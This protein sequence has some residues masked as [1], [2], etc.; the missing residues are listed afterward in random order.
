[1]WPAPS[2]K[3]LKMARGAK[4]FGHPCYGGIPYNFHSRARTTNPPSLS[5]PTKP[6]FFLPRSERRGKRKRN[7]RGSSLW[8]GFFSFFLYAPQEPKKKQTNKKEHEKYTTHAAP[9]KW[10]RTWPVAISNWLNP[11]ED[12]KPKREKETTTKKRQSAEKQTQKRAKKKR[13]KECGWFFNKRL[14]ILFFALSNFLVAFFGF[15]FEGV[16]LGDKSS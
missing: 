6:P 2:S 11:Q 1:M 15:L 12:R 4:K 7:K 16:G 3:F 5:V 10:W 14:V 13:T 9:G 8:F